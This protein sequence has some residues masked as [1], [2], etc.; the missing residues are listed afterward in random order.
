M[1]CVTVSDDVENAAI[2]VEPGDTVR[3]PLTVVGPAST[4]QAPEI[5]TFPEMVPLSVPT[6]IGK[7]SALTVQVVVF[8]AAV[9][10]VTAKI[11]GSVGRCVIVHKRHALG[12]ASATRPRSGLTGP[13]LAKAA[14][15]FR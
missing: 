14:P 10:A 5:V 13:L 6:V 15:R 8:A 12:L 9:P 3:L 7:L 2:S 4:A 11:G 1:L